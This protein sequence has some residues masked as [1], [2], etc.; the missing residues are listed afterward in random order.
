VVKLKKT[1]WKWIGLIQ[2]TLFL[3]FFIWEFIDFNM[4]PLTQEY[5]T[6]IASPSFLDVALGVS[7]VTAMQFSSL[8]LLI[9]PFIYWFLADLSHSFRARKPN[10]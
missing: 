1:D 9:V 5:E 4:R 10:P 8:C 2:V 3:F 7:F 6:A